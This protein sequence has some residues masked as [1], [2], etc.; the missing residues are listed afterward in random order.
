MLGITKTI[1][2]E[3]RMK[4]FL[5]KIKPVKSGCWEWTGA[6][7][8]HNC[9]Y[10]Y[11]QN[12]RAHRVSY[13]CYKGS[14]PKGLTINHDCNNTRCVNPEHL[15]AMSLRNNLLL[16]TSFVAVNARKTHCKHGHEFTPENTYAKAQGCRDCK[17]CRKAAHGR[18]KSKK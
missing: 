9:S 11:Y 16:G 8:G 3:K 4:A 1:H 13:E 14:I 7:S 6:L 5:A 12:R 10:P 15:T 18:F 17:I 2:N